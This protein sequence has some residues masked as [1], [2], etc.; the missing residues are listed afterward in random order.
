MTRKRLI[1]GTV[2]AFLTP[3]LAAASIC[4]G[5][6]SKA[7]IGARYL[8]TEFMVAAL[9]CRQDPGLRESYASFVRRYNPGLVSNARTMKAQFGGAGALDTYV[10]RLA[11]HAALRSQNERP[12]CAHARLRLDRALAAETGSELDDVTEQLGYGL[13][14][15]ACGDLTPVAALERKG[16]IT[17]E[18]PPPAPARAPGNAPAAGAPSS[19]SGPLVE[20]A[21]GDPSAGG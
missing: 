21:S 16:R 13:G 6:V 17:A 10:T 20:P 9:M 19:P 7:E 2:L 12:Y 14:G 5:G 3:S 1:A 15:P 11:N 8:L 4:P 18:P